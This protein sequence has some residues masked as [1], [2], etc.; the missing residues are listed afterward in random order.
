[1]FG[2]VICKCRCLMSPMF[3]H[4]DRLAV[5]VSKKTGPSSSGGWGVERKMAEVRKKVRVTADGLRYC[6]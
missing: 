4:R 6:M 5:D 3:P 2:R 1:M